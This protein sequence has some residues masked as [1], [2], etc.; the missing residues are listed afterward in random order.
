MHSRKKW[1]DYYNHQRIKTKLG[2]SPVQFRKR[3]VA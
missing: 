3:F 2:C 1:I